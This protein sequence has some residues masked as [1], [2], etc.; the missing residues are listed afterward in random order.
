MSDADDP[1]NYDF[2]FIDSTITLVQS[3]GAQPFITMD[4]MP[5][6]LSSDTTPEYQGAMGLLYFLAYDNGIRN[7]P[8]ANNAVYGRVMY[9]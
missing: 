8:P 2:A 5:F 3:I 6:T 7:S 4:Y 1:G 9:H